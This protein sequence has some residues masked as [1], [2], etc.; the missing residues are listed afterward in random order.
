MKV[1]LALSLKQVGFWIGTM[2][3]QTYVESL[4]RRSFF[5]PHV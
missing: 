1:A 3:L 5:Q 2:A 4:W